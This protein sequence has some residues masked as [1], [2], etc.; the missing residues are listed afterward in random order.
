MYAPH[1]LHASEANY[2]EPNVE[3][4]LELEKPQ[5]SDQVI[6]CKKILAG[7]GE[8]LASYTAKIDSDPEPS[9]LVEPDIVNESNLKVVDKAKLEPKV[10]ASY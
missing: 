4:E 6:E 8:L 7:V 9:V 2:K 5:F 3:H 1:L 10:R